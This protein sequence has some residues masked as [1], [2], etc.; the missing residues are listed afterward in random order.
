MSRISVWEEPIIYLDLIGKIGDFK[1][2]NAII[3][4]NMAWKIIAILF[5]RYGNFYI[6]VMLKCALRGHPP[7]A[8]ITRC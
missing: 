8:L 7:L 3:A 1:A 6:F 2:L 5:A 4:P